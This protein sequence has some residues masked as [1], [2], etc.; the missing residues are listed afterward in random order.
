MR[1][2]KKK[3]KGEKIKGEIIEGGKQRRM[4]EGGV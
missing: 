1:D 3:I 2:G 4:K